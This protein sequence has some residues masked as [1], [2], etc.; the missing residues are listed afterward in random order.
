MEMVMS[1]VKQPFTELRSAGMDLIRV[2][3][4]QPWGQTTLNNHPGF[5]EYLLDR[6]TEKTK[7]GK[8]GK[9]DI[10][11]TLVESPSAQEIFG[12]VYFVRLREYMNEG[13][14]YTRVEAAVAFESAEWLM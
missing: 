8:E 3:S 4:N 9:W 5:F 1:L 12:N 13:A 2:I 14:F 10:V 11:K 7:E 6:S